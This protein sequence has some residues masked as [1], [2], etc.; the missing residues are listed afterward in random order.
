MKIG[1][2]HI[3]GSM[4]GKHIEGHAGNDTN[5]GIGGDDWPNGGTGVDRFYGGAGLDGSSGIDLPTFWEVSTT[6]H[7]VKV[8]RALAPNQV[9]NNG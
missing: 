9:I 1:D 7:G 4:F 5:F 6:E 8:N 2:D 3:N